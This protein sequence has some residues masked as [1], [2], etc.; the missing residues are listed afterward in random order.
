M[1]INSIDGIANGL[2]NGAQN[3][4]INKASVSTQIAGGFSSLWRT[5][6]LPA[7]GPV[8]TAATACNKATVGSFVFPNA[9]TGLSNYIARMSTT[10]ANAS[11]DIQIHDRLAHMGGLS[12]TVVTAQTV[13]LDVTATANRNGPDT[14]AEV[15]WWLE[16]YTATGS[17][18]TVATISYTN[19]EGTA[20]RTTTVSIAASTAASR[21]FQIIGAGG[22]F[23]QSIQSVTLS[24]TSGTVGNFGVTATRFI[25]GHTTAAA[26][27]GISSDWQMLGLPRVEDDACLFFTMVASTTTTGVIYGNVK[28]IQG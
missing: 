8:P 22:E 1:A 28:I 26:N 3:V 20:G 15:Q 17:T 9:P 7:Q 10:A 11:T 14:F 18:A 13:N 24:V 4:V 12:G 5:T 23:I 16:W 2:G 25:G 19:A 27:T 6:G 21:M